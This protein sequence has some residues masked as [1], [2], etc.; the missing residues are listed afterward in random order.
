MI[1]RKI[2]L[3]LAIASLTVV[4][5]FVLMS[6]EYFTQG[7]ILILFAVI[8]SMLAN[9]EYKYEKISHKKWQMLIYAIISASGSW[10]LLQTTTAPTLSLTLLVVYTI[11]TLYLLTQSIR[12]F[13]T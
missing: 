6:M 9:T 12:G 1:M 10:S 11:L 2:L 3:L 8:L 5:G 4:T 13:R 7:A